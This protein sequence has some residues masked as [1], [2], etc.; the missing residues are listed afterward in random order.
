MRRTSFAGVQV[1][2]DPSFVI[3]TPVTNQSVAQSP[4]SPSTPPRGPRSLLSP[5]TGGPAKT[6]C[7]PIAGEKGKAGDGCWWRWQIHFSYA[8]SIVFGGI[9][10]GASCPE[11]L[12]DYSA[13]AATSATSVELLRYVL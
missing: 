10:T 13:A 7:P 1:G 4:S 9:G 2:R 3:T 11:W 6:W 5:S 8:R 12:R